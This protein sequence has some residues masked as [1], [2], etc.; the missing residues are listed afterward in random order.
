MS[1]RGFARP[2]AN[3]RD[4]SLV[5]VVG[6]H[7]HANSGRLQ[8]TAL[9]FLAC[10]AGTADLAGSTVPRQHRLITAT[11][12]SPYAQKAG[13]VGGEKTNGA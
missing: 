7:V 3:P 11:A 1:E 8:H 2:L 10:S 9:N 5:V 4:P 6:S 13:R 12:V